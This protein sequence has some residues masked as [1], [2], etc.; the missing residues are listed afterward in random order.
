[1]KQI[2]RAVARRIC[3]EKE[4]NAEIDVRYFASA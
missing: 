1:M 2:R 4:R 3:F